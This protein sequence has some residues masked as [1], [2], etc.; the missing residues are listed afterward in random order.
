MIN[1]NIVILSFV[2]FAAGIIDNISGGG[3][4]L[5]ITALLLVGLPP[6]V[7]LG[8]DKLVATVSTL[9]ALY[10]YIRHKK[11]IWKLIIFGIAFSL[12]GS[13]IGTKLI[14]SIPNEL[15]GKIIIFLLP[16]ALFVILLPKKN[17]REK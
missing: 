14:L 2:A 6:K 4:L 12:L 17:V 11:I 1:I 3:G 10:N 13:F 7:V 9:P 15:V 16:L 5:Q 8:T